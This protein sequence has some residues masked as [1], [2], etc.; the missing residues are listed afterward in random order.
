MPFGRVMIL[1]SDAIGLP[2][3]NIAVLPLFSATVH[4]GGL[5]AFM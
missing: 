5:G 1:L 4:S 2:F 3:S